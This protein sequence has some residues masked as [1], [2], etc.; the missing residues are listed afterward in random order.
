MPI[1][2]EICFNIPFFSNGTMQLT[3]S[4]SLVITLA[5]LGGSLKQPPGLPRRTV[6]QLAIKGVWREG[7]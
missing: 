7:E 4:R 6:S 1:K 5:V 2:G 3:V